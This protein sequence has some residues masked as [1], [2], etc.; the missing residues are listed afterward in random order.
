MR[1]F[2]AAWPDDAARRQCEALTDALRPHAQH[3]RVMRPEN[4]HLTMAF[5]GELADER[6]ARVAARCAAL[7]GIGCDWQLDEIGHFARPRVLWA[8]GPLSA[9]LDAIAG[10]ARA[11]LDDLQIDYDRKPFVP[12]VTLLRDVRRYD[13]PRTI[14][15]PIAWPIC[16]IALYR[17]GRDD[18]GARYVGVEPA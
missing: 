7:S 9:A 15:P 11:L 1:C 18:A 4:L 2:I 8:G 12:H 13:G 3:G 5:I 14:A 17:S 10:R 16:S 6:G